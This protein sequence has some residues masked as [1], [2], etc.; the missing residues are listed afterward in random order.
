[1][2]GIE[3][4]KSARHN[5]SGDIKLSTKFEKNEGGN[6]AQTQLGSTA[7]AMHY[8]IWSYQFHPINRTEIIN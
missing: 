4:K 6:C 1:M 3:Y 8:F 2:H 7:H 5:Q